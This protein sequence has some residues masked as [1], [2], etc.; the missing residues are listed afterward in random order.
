[1]NE[2]I[3][4]IGG[5]SVLGAS[6]FYTKFQTNQNAKDIDVLKAELKE[7]EKRDAERQSEV[8]V[9]REKILST[10]KQILGVEQG[11]AAKLDIISNTLNDIWRKFEKYD[12]RIADLYNK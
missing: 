2:F 5:I 4:I 7:N 1:M 3:E 9:L 10:E 8:R 6:I 11:I 12:D